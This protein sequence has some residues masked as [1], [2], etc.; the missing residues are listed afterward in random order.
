MSKR[1]A[2]DT[3][4]EQRPG[5]ELAFR[6]MNSTVM[7]AIRLLSER[8]NFRAEYHRT[9]REIQDLVNKSTGRQREAL[10]ALFD[11]LKTQAPAVPDAAPFPVQ[12]KLVTEPLDMETSVALLQVKEEKSSAKKQKTEAQRIRAK[13]KREKQLLKKAKAL[14]EEEQKPPVPSTNKS[15]DQESEQTS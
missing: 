12:T 11:A 3:R 15:Q 7:E 2:E 10:N 5:W 8:E 4:P 9:D 6:T 13:A 14:V 1:K